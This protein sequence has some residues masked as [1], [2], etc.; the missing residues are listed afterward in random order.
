MRVG[1]VGAGSWGT[2][3]AKVVAEAG[4]AVLYQGLSPM[5]AVGYLMGR[6]PRQELER[7]TP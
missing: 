4:H 3:L 1:V 6:Q 7:F 5:D 2:A